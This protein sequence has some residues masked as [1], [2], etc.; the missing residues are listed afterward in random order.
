[1][2][3]THDQ[4]ILLYE[5]EHNKV[6]HEFKA[7]IADD[8]VEHCISFLKGCGYC[9]STIYQVMQEKAEMFFEAEGTLRL[10]AQQDDLIGLD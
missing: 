3:Q 6:L 10:P 2:T 1:M 4:Y 9:E 8:V 7:L 5:D